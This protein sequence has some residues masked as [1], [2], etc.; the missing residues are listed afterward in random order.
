MSS[1]QK[2]SKSKF[3]V[4]CGWPQLHCTS[5]YAQSTM[6][7][8]RGCATWYV[9]IIYVHRPAVKCQVTAQLK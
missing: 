8:V 9:T 7:Q 4:D 5:L 2:I 1:I 3:I 6:L